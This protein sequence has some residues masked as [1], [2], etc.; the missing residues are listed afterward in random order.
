MRKD[1]TLWRD[2]IGPHEFLMDSRGDCHICG[3]RDGDP[4][5]T[6]HSVITHQGDQIKRLLDDLLHTA[7]QRDEYRERAYKAELMGGIDRA[8]NSLGYSKVCGDYATG[9]N[10]DLCS[11]CGH[12][13]FEHE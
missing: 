11:N 8:L 2:G 4:R 5:H 7:K 12:T 13:R 1:K 9:A 6:P 10:S 3:Q